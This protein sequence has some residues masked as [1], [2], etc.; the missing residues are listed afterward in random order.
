MKEYEPIEG[1]EKDLALTGTPEE[2][3]A[4]MKDIY[5]SLD[6][7]E[8]KLEFLVKNDQYQEVLDRVDGER[9]ASAETDWI[10]AFRRVST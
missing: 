10:F 1:Q 6:T 4:K 8:E 3:A 7:L 9:P 2:R 5:D